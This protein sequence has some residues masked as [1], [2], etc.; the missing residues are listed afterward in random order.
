METGLK[1]IMIV[2][3]GLVK[4][5]FTIKMVI[6]F[7]ENI[8]KVKQSKENNFLKMVIFNNVNIKMVK[9]M[10]KEKKYLKM[11]IYSKDSIKMVIGMEKEWNT[12]K[13]ETNLNVIML[14]EKLLEWE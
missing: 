14:M 13:M 1:E 5:L 3:N 4:V 10:V 2:E 6:D 12:L 11:V 7:K 9:L 8:F